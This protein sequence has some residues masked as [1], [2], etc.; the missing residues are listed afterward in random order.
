MPTSSGDIPETGRGDNS[1]RVQTRADR[2]AAIWRAG[3]PVVI[4]FPAV[5]AVLGIAAIFSLWWLGTSVT[6]AY[7]LW[8]IVVVTRASL[9]RESKP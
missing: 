8:A 7:T 9:F 5:V 2:R 1:Q 3:R 4:A 6:L